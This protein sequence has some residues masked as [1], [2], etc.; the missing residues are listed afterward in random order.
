MET[1]N[2]DLKTAITLYKTAVNMIVEVKGDLMCRPDPMACQAYI[3]KYFFPSPGRHI[4]FWD[5]KYKTFWKYT[6]T[7]MKQTFFNRMPKPIS[8]WFF[9]EYKSKFEITQDG[10]SL[11]NN[12]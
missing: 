12:T 10:K 9:Y 4:F 3:K 11:I 7:E 5:A 1:E 2:F 8:V 6:R